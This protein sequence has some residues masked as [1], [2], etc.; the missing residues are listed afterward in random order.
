MEARNLKPISE[1]KYPEIPSKFITTIT[2]SLIY[3]MIQISFAA[4]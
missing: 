2:L 4:L 1:I 3:R